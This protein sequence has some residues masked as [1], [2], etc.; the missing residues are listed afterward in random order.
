MEKKRLA[1][2]PDVLTQNEV[3]AIFC[4]SVRT[5]QNWIRT[6]QLPYFRAGNC[7]RF[8]KPEIIARLRDID[9]G[10]SLDYNSA[11]E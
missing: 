5:I 4:V 2:Y 9:P 1:D 11:R 10:D 6:N 8:Y 7:V 3:A